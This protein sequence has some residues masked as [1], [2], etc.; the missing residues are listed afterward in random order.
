MFK[1]RLTLRSVASLDPNSLAFIFPFKYLCY[2]AI[3]PLHNG[4][5]Q[6]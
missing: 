4:I 2:K 6:F 5:Q 1:K 3:E